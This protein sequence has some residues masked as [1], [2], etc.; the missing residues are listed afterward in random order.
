MVGPTV[1]RK[2]ERET[3]E[4]GVKK[5]MER[6]GGAGF[7]VVGVRV[8]GERRRCVRHGGATAARNT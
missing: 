4:E 7:G 8:R 3:T 2:G 1:A 6:G 5:G